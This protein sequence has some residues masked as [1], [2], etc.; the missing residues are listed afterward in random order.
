VCCCML[1]KPETSLAKPSSLAGD[2]KSSFN[3]PASFA[4][5]FDAG[6]LAFQDHIEARASASINGTVLSLQVTV[7]EYA[8]GALPNLGKYCYNSMT[9]TQVS[10]GVARGHRL[11]GARLA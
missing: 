10:S 5:P 11:Y 7:V 2:S 9:S 8:L 3:Q 6:I 1:L 4:R